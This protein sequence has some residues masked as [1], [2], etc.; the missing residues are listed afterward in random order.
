M[1][2]TDNSLHALDD[3]FITNHRGRPVVCIGLR[4]TFYLD[5]GINLE[6]RLR[7]GRCAEDYLQRY[8]DKIRKTQIQCGRWRKPA[9]QGMEDFIASIT[10]VRE[11]HHR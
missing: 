8:G 7:I 10:L 4:Q 6:T 3:I 1:P 2:N 5:K 11:A 9:K